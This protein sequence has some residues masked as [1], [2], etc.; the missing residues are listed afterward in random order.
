MDTDKYGVKGKVDVGI[1]KKIN[2]ENIPSSG[3]CCPHLHIV[4]ED[5]DPFQIRRY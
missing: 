3:K 5:F 1:E 2:F 4:R